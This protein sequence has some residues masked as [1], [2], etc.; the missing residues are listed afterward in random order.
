[1]KT[2]HADESVGDAAL[3]QTGEQKPGTSLETSGKENA[4]RVKEPQRKARGKG[5]QNL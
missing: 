5:P 4:D 2:I 3:Q 1:M